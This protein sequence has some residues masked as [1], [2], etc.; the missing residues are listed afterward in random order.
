MKFFIVFLLILGFIFAILFFILDNLHAGGSPGSIQKK[1][2]LEA[3]LGRQVIGKAIKIDY[4]MKSYEGK[5]I[6]FSYPA[7][8]KTQETHNT[9]AVILD[10]F[11]ATSINP[12]LTVAATAVKTE[13]QLENFPGA[14]VRTQDPKT[15]I[16]FTPQAKSIP[17]L[18]F[19]KKIDQPE[20]TGFFQLNGKI[21]S[22]SVT[23]IDLDEVKK[24]FNEIASTLE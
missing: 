9:S 2:A 10:S 6:H 15:Y 24:Y 5:Y 20:V 12:Q 3:L 21:V 22:V 14:A 7:F 19:I 18:G 4:S 13:D 16:P 17:G 1:Q 23:G 11:F 8:L